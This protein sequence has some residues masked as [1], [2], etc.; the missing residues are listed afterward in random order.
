MVNRIKKYASLFNKSDLHAHSTF[1]D[2]RNSVQEMVFAAKKNGL[3]LFAITEHVR[4]VLTYDFEA[5]R[6]EVK[7]YDSSEFTV[8]VGCEAKVLDL[9]G[10]IDVSDEVLAKCDLVIGS[11]HG[12]SGGKAEYLQAVSAMLRNGVID[13]WGHP[14]LFP[15]KRNFELSIAEWE[16][17][18]LASIEGDVFLEFNSR[19][20]LPPK[21]Y[22]ERAI[23]LGAKFVV[24]SDAHSVDQIRII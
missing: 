5:L 13:V 14:L 17:L 7:S 18:V 23:E 10:S 8:L 16:A 4:K 6:R 15:K 12:F 9:S 20:S 1:T 11:V 3:H 24:S 2:G 21:Q 22:R 19:Y